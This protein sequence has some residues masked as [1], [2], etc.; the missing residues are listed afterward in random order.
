[1]EPEKLITES[2]LSQE[3]KKL[4][5]RAGF[6]TMR[7][8]ETYTRLGFKERV[9]GLKVRQLR[10]L[11]ENDVV[12]KKPDNSIWLDDFINE[13]KLFNLWRDDIFTYEQ[14]GK[15]SYL[16][17]IFYLGGPQSR[18]ARNKKKS[19]EWM[20]EH[21]IV[22]EEQSAHLQHISNETASLLFKAGIS[23]LENL[24]DITDIRL[25]GILRAGSEAQTHRRVIEVKYALIKAGL[26]QT[27]KL[28]P[29]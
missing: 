14:L 19:G 27:H 18:F 4:L 21:D 16:D 6:V 9:K 8:I 5:K 20:K 26:S 12:F 29:S 23:N 11:I 28:G 7:E 25:H 3:L 13:R 15:V 17:F 10:S 1:M 24:V 22:I 2:W